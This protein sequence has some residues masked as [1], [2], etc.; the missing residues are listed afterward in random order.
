MDTSYQLLKEKIEAVLRNAITAADL[1]KVSA[2]L[3]IYEQKNGLFM[4]RVRV[5]GGDIQA[6]A[7]LRLAEVCLN[8]DI[9]NI[10][11]TTRQDIQLHDVQLKNIHQTVLHAVKNGF[12]FRGG[13]GDTFRN[14][15]IDEYSDISPEAVFD[16]RPHALALN[17]F[18]LAYDNA[19]ALPR[20]LKIGFFSGVEKNNAAL[21]QDISFNAVKHE[22]H[23]AFDV[24]AGGG[25]GRESRK[26]VKIFS[27][28]PERE[29][30]RC[31]AAVVELF[32][33]HG[34]REKRNEAR[35]RF[36]L[37]RLGE[38]EFVRLF[39]Q[40]FEKTDVDNVEKSFG[41]D[42]KTSDIPVFEEKTEKD[43]QYDKWL[44]RSVCETGIKDI[45]ALKIIVPG[46]NLQ[47]RHLTSLSHLAE[48]YSN[49]IIRLLRSQ[50]ILLPKAHR[51]ALPYIYEELRNG[52][53]SVFLEAAFHSKIVSCVGAAVC[54][55]GILDSAKYASALS[56]GLDMLFED[57]PDI[58]TW[59]KQQIT[60]SIRISGC[61]NSCGGHTASALGF[62]GL[63]RNIGEVSEPCFR[64]FTG[65]CQEG[66]KSRLAVAAENFYVPAKDLPAFVKE[67]ATAY[68]KRN[69]R[70]ETFADYISGIGTG[71]MDRFYKFKQDRT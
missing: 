4:V 13:G 5:A 2:P 6:S 63:K 16:V 53:L 31:A 18:L 71:N 35:L 9:N 30:F 59:D 37:N 28:L 33:D 19:F 64:V 41:I 12:I 14:L 1:K 11:L 25:L 26:G 52:D 55:I 61:P 68:L 58:S 34:N 46:G 23:K 40:Y 32:N 43:A 22:N 70:T 65:G 20:K 49:G 47:T 44:E 56:H 17:K 67:L 48:K 66:E 50:D 38:Q 42:G 62:E 51:T 10:H 15:L 57:F 60:D 21:F 29:I 45:Y 3:G 8:N 39:L 7:L 27:A 54:K 36:V 24:Y 69:N